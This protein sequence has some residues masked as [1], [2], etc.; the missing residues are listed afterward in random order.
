MPKRTTKSK[1]LKVNEVSIPEPI[2]RMIEARGWHFPPTEEEIKQRL[3]VLRRFAGASKTDP[4]ILYAVA[5]DTDPSRLG[6]T[7]EDL[8]KLKRRA[9]KS[10]SRNP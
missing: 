3:E 8:E 1:R 6:L 9:E 2:K 5:M 7:V 10:A 4:E